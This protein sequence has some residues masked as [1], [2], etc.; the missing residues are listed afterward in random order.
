MNRIYLPLHSI[1]ICM[2]ECLKLKVCTNNRLVKSLFN[3]VINV[4]LKSIL[5]ERPVNE[6]E[7][8]EIIRINAQINGLTFILETQLYDKNVI[9]AEPFSFNSLTVPSDITSSDFTNLIPNIHRL[10]ENEE[11]ESQ[12]KQTKLLVDNSS[13]S[14]SLLRSINLVDNETLSNKLERLN[15]QNEKIIEL[16]N[17]LERKNEFI[18]KQNEKIIEKQMEHDRFLELSYETANCENNLSSA[19]NSSCINVE[20]SSM[21]EQQPST[22]SGIFKRKLYDYSFELTQKEFNR[23]VK[24]SMMQHIP[25]EDQH[26]GMTEMCEKYPDEINR[27]KASLR[28]FLPKGSTFTIA[29]SKALHTFRQQKYMERRLKK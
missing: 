24:S 6:L 11:N 7:D 4:D 10:N 29:W 18:I 21:S 5:L 15:H 19:S 25:V 13:S 22:S 23:K 12:L 1:P 2:N 8:D 26:L 16:I 27:I 28:N 20:K 17:I 9:M 14:F 3:K